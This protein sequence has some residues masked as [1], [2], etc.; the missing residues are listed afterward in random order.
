[1]PSIL[2]EGESEG[3]LDTEEEGFKLTSDLSV[4][5]L[6]SPLRYNPFRPRTP[7]VVPFCHHP[8]LVMTTNGDFE[9]NTPKRFDSGSADVCAFD[10]ICV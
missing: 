6:V 8:T 3:A 2:R 7:T 5:I 4:K 1:M 9:V 10:T